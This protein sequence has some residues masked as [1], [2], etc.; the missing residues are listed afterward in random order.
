MPGTNAEYFQFACDES[1]SSDFAT[2]R[3]WVDGSEITAEEAADIR[4]LWVYRQEQIERQVSKKKRRKAQSKALRVLRRY[5]STGQLAGLRRK[6]EFY[7]T[8]PSGNTYRLDARRGR[9]EDVARHGKRYFV[10]R[11]F[12]LHEHSLLVLPMPPADLALT[13][14]LLLLADEQ[15]FLSLANA[16][17][18]NDMLWHGP[19]LRRLR[20]AR[21]Q[22]MA[23]DALS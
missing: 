20:E 1:L 23:G 21:L 11:R 2:G 7:L 4:A 19:W 12:C 9:T 15:E 18:A 3:T 17:N 22:R 5:L 13:H 10:R 14:F 8:L 6:G 16:T